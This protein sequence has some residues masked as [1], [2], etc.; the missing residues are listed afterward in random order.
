MP[1]YGGPSESG[2][3]SWAGVRGQVTLD[4]SDYDIQYD[5]FPLTF[6]A[7][8]DA[9]NEQALQVASI[10]HSLEDVVK[11]NEWRLR[12]I[13]GKSFIW[14]LGDELDSP[15]VQ[16]ALVDCAVGFI[17]CKTDD[18]GTPD[19]WF[20]EVNP[21]SQFSA[22]DPWIWRRRWLLNPYSASDVRDSTV[23]LMNNFPYADIPGSNINCGSAVDGPHIDQKTARRIHRNER[24]FCVVAARPHTVNFVDDYGAV[25]L[26]YLLDYRLLGSLVGSAIG[27][28]GN[29]SR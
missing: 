4:G 27:N 13:V 20:P 3:T 21:L 19:T 16:G 8:F 11:G 1:T 18:D 12:R 23:S 7:G 29:A 5:A 2:D 28:R 17:V 14:V 25:V 24:L 22:D 15:A 9:P 26:Q 6:D 10:P